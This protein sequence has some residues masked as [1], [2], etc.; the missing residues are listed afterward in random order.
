MSDNKTKYYN[1]ENFDDGLEDKKPAVKKTSHKK[2]KKK[3]SGNPVKQ[4][5][6]IIGTTLLSLVMIVVITGCIVATAFTVYV[7]QF[8]DSA[9]DV[10]LQN[11]ELSYTSFIYAT[12]KDGNEIEV[13]RLS[14]D[15]NRIWVDI[16]DIPRH[17]QDAYIAV[18]DKRFFEH[19][20][21]DWIR[22]MYVAASTLF[23]GYGQ[24]GSTITQQLVKNITGDDRV[25][26][27]R[28]FREI[29][30]A[31]TLETKY[32]KIDILEAY[33]NRV[34][35]GNT[36]YG[37]G[38]AAYHY[39]G[40]S[41]DQLTIAES[42]ILAGMTSSPGVANPYADLEL[43]RKNQLNALAL[44][45]EQGLITTAEYEQARNEKVQ[46]RLIVK[47]DAYG[48]TDPRY[49]EYYG[50]NEDDEDEDLDDDVLY[51]DEDDYEAYRWNDYDVTQN[52]YVDAAIEQVIEDL[53]EM[54]GLSYSA[55]REAVYSG[56][57]KIYLNMDMELQEKL[58]EFFKDPYNFFP[59]YDTQALEEDL[60]QGAFVL[61]DFH[62]RIVAL[63]GGIGDK[64]GENCFN[65]AT[66][67]L[68]PIGSTMKPISVYGQLIDKD[69]ISYSSPM[70][71]APSVILENGS[72]WPYNF[73]NM[74]Y[75]D[76]VPA[77]YAVQQ[78]INTCAVR[79][80]QLLGVET[81]FDF[82]SEKLGVTTLDYT[83]DK[84]LSPIALG[85]LTEGMYLD[86]LAGAFQ[87]FGTGGIYYDLKLYSKVTDYNDKVIL[88]MDTIGERVMDSD[89]AYIT[90]RMMKTVV[91]ATSGTTGRYAKI[92]GMEVV[93]KTGTS[94]DDRIVAFAGLTPEYVGVIRI[95][96]DDNK[97]IYGKNYTAMGQVWHDFM[98]TIIDDNSIKTFTADPNVVQRNYCTSSGLL[99]GSKCTSTNVG[100][101]KKD[102]LPKVCNYHGEGGG[103]T[104]YGETLLEP[105][106]QAT[107]TTSNR[108][109]SS[110]SSGS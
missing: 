41:V 15:E 13:T 82:L 108:N 102:T 35:L 106:W 27:D 71:D 3:K 43:S 30:R 20:G 54:K 9:F 39:F 11:V 73:E 2:K 57:Y 64:P 34:P 90:N 74:H 110:T 109:E 31:L 45:Y 98:V 79:G 51:N 76:Y 56:G 19:D 52:W 7:M 62:G 85:Q 96:Y 95:G 105:D 55:A 83:N 23:N 4:V 50:T 93:G 66:M 69:I 44:M 1:A 89:S 88:E 48:Y 5:L 6:G 29:F 22:T 32:T 100:Y 37:V 92:E 86:E 65:R 17:L 87:I 75:G 24:G 72:R 60:I 80:A 99:A 78:S 46:F 70:R 38:S 77:W 59:Y 8:A 42:A 53:A 33:L 47:G 61:A 14:G 101:Y 12:D 63:A 28:K 49:E 97:S 81:C 68:L 84:A 67:G 18:E 91:E 16:E 10:D 36:V 58:E 103:S 40:K 107:T 94:N 25:S 26:P 21:V 104:H